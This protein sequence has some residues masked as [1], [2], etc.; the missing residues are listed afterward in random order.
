MTPGI[1]EK[2]LDDLASILTV[3]SLVAFEDMEPEEM[4][5]VARGGFEMVGR[6]Q[7]DLEH[8]LPV[9]SEATNKPN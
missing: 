8:V 2:T 3:L 1:I 4:R 7:R 9:V 5:A 6:L